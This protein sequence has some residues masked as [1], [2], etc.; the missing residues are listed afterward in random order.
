MKHKKLLLLIPAAVYLLLLRL[1]VLAEASVPD[2]TIRTLPQALWYS[3][4]TLSTVGYGDLAPV[5]PW[6]RL[7]GTVFVLCSS[8]LL[9]TLISLCV[10]FL[11]SDTVQ[12]L[13]LSQKR[14]Q[15]WFLFSVPCP[16][17]D[18]LIDG[19]RQDRPQ[20]LF[21]VAGGEGAASRL[22]LEELLELRGEGET[23]VFCLGPDGFQNYR[24]AAALCRPGLTVAA[25]T[26]CA[27]DSVP[28]ELLLFDPARLCARLYWRRYPLRSLTEEIVLIGGGPFAEALLEM[29]L[30]VNVRSPEQRLRYT[31]FG[32]FADFRREHPSLQRLSEP[33]LL[34]FPE[35]PWNQ[36]LEL[37][38]QADRIIVC[39]DEEAET[40]E[41]LRRLLRACPLSGTVYARLSEPWEGV[42]VFGSL[43]ELYD[44][45]LVLRRRLDKAGRAMHELYRRDSPDAPVWEELSAFTRRSNL[46]AADH[47]PVKLSI[48][49]ERD[50]EIELNRETLAA[51][52]ARYL[53]RRDRDAWLFRW[54]EHRRWCRF[55]LMNNWRYAPRRDDA[56]RLHPMLLPLEELRP[57]DQA[58]DDYAWE[59]L[60]KLAEE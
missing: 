4:V 13:R 3:L 34:S 48:L 22:S 46:A 25:E 23:Q 47:L 8:F 51:A 21:L 24:R 28:P 19:L 41:L 37:L 16:E 20:G 42:T 35:T 12:K 1:L 5:S 50:G 11:R 6:G 56:R 58:K 9:V 36:D 27:P 15:P 40:L 39:Q 17:A 32:P 7:I 53:E 30:L 55:H 29:G 2:A 31:V 14:R 59:L 45:E 60:G 38:R 44:P 57:F 54:V 52:Y 49:L 43:A 18:A 33:D 26:A 10:D